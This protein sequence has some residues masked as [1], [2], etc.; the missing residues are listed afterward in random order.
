MSRNDNEKLKDR[1]VSQAEC[2]QKSTGVQRNTNR[3][4]RKTAMAIG[5]ADCGQRLRV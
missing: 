1:V 5:S 2:D 4:A 3:Q